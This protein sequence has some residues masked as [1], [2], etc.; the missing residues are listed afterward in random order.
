[1]TFAAPG[2]FPWLT[3][4]G[5]IPLLGALLLALIP[6]GR[7]EFVKRLALAVSLVVLGFA[8]AMSLAYD[9]HKAGFQFVENHSWIRQFGVHY[10]LGADGIALVLIDLVA[11][12]TPVVVLASWRDADPSADGVTGVLRNRFGLGSVRAFFALLLSLETMLVGVFGAT[13]IFLF[14]VFFEAMLIPMYFLIGSFGGPQRSYASMKFL[15]YSLFGGLLML[16]AVIGLYVASA[17]E[18]GHGT[19]ALAQLTKLHL[20]H[21]V[22]DALFLGFFIA[23]AIK[24]PLWP[25]HTWLPDAGAES[26]IGAAVLLVGVLDKVGTFGFIRYCI[27][28]FPA[29]S[30]TFAPYV[31]ALAVVGVIYGA[32]VAMA[33]RDLKRLVSYTSVAHF[34]FIAMGVFAFTS[35]GGTGAVLYMV[36]HG[37][38]TGALFLVVGFLVARSGSRNIDDHGGLAKPAPLLGG[39]FLLAG[40]S[41]LALPGLSTFVSEFLVL[42]GTFTRYGAAAI[43]A[44]T[45]IVLAA[46]YVL[47]A[48]QRTMQGPLKAG[49]EAVKDLSAR[50]VFVIAPVLTLI[51]VLGFYPKPLLDVI[52]PSVQ[53]TYQL[54]H[55]G[56]PAP[57]AASPPPLAAGAQK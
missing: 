15:L 50:E 29:A 11:V 34:G 23:F 14:Y 45:G 7:D 21:Q 40:L 2:G 27:P 19:F 54:A 12:L 10:A 1:M 3:V 55:R 39:A 41:S 13:D 47:I 20:S 32:L 8:V 28:L 48:Y 43:V 17:H 25:F 30:K 24:A 38:S 42:V 52:T 37:L 22:Q 49:L 53:A 51:V 46:L 6:A 9:T 16:A 57:V 33:Q 56:D 35:Q 31:I 36:N 26:P 18:L 44:T 4:L 5:A